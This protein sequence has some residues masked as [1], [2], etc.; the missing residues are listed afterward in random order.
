MTYKLVSNTYHG[1]Q[2]P[3]VVNFN[4]CSQKVPQYKNVVPSLD[5]LTHGVSNCNG[6]YFTIAN[7]YPDY[8]KNCTQ[9]VQKQCNQ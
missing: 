1:K 5:A 3:S 8:N 4:M 2:A 7:A 6:G 9:Y